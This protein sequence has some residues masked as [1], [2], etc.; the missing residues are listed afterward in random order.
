MGP[1]ITAFVRGATERL[2]MSVGLA[3]TIHAAGD[4]PPI[5]IDQG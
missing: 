1:V 3:L 4:Q 2:A 5:S